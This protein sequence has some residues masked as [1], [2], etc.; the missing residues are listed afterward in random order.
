MNRAED[1]TRVS[2][3]VESKHMENKPMENKPMENK[4]ENA[5]I[6]EILEHFCGSFSDAKYESIGEQDR[7]KFYVQD[8]ADK[9]EFQLQVYNKMF[10]NEI[11]L[12][13]NKYIKNRIT[14]ESNSYIKNKLSSTNLFIGKPSLL[15]NVFNI[16]M[17][18]IA[19]LLIKIL[20]SIKLRMYGTNE[21]IQV[22]FNI[23]YPL[24]D[25][26]TNILDSID[27]DD[28]L[29]IDTILQKDSYKYVASYVD[30]DSDRRIY[31]VDSIGGIEVAKYL[32]ENHVCDHIIYLCYMNC[33]ASSSLLVL[34]IQ[35]NL[36][37]HSY[38]STWYDLINSIIAKVYKMY[39]L[40]AV[41]DDQY[42]HD[43]E[44][45][46]IRKISLGVS[47]KFTNKQ[48]LETTIGKLSNSLVND[49]CLHKFNFLGHLVKIAGADKKSYSLKDVS[50]ALAITY[51]ETLKYFSGLE[52][53]SYNFEK[54]YTTEI[55]QLTLLEGELEVDKKLYR[56]MDTSK[57]GINIM[58]RCG[59]AVIQSNENIGFMRS[60][61]FAQINKVKIEESE[62]NKVEHKIYKYMHER[63]T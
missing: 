1:G 35:G 41:G 45:E 51:L 9:I 48:F 32:Y 58:H 5:L 44:K 53:N 62:I 43:L 3:T 40:I 42:A 2:E 37:N 14:L 36:Y 18:S 63:C 61:I 49:L 46:A 7:M 26:I 17:S 39:T 10:E 22:S 52:V 47:T 56:N 28:I 13:S 16:F 4:F 19:D 59:L 23:N 55:G 31:S 38:V 27:T 25:N 60:F 33:A 34:N 20:G 12:N 57:I 21:I 11:L 29:D 8:I 24:L 50:R 6:I 30:H 54:Y 15:A